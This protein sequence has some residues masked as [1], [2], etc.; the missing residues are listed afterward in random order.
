MIRLPDPPKS[1]IPDELKKDN[2][3]FHVLARQNDPAIKTLNTV[4]LITNLKATIEIG[5]LYT[6]CQY[7][8]ITAPVFFNRLIVQSNWAWNLYS[9]GMIGQSVEVANAVL[10]EVAPLLYD[11][12]FTI[13]KADSFPAKVRV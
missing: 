13:S 6:D 1:K 7:S 3:A 9:R 5:E 4:E 12:R 10:K 8:M 2:W 11:S